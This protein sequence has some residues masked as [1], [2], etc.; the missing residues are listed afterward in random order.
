MPTVMKLSTASQSEH[1]GHGGPRG[2]L[3]RG[4]PMGQTVLSSAR[5]CP[6]PCQQSCPPPRLRQPQMPPDAPKP[7]PGETPGCQR[8]VGGGLCLSLG[9]QTSFHWKTGNKRSM[10]GPWNT[11]RLPDH[12][13]PR[14]R[15][16]PMAASDARPT[17]AQTWSLMEAVPT[18]T[19]SGLAHAEFQEASRAVV[20]R[21]LFRLKGQ[22][23]N[24]GQ[25]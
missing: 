15:P 20:W 19:V 12:F 1:H 16:W 25:V 6:G 8:C 4:C 2:S 10:T 9:S 24:G 21:T 5:G 3:Q 14:A 13:P 22:A 11:S 17:P 18:A 7:L 23:R